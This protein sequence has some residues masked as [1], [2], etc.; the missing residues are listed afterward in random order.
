MIWALLYIAV[1]AF[2]VSLLAP[3]ALRPILERWG[4]LD[5]PNDRSSHTIATLR[6]GGL[7]PLAGWTIGIATTALLLPDA[8]AWLAILGVAV[9]V[10]ALLGLVDDLRSLPASPR[11]VVQMLVSAAAAFAIAGPH[12]WMAVALAAIII[13]GYVNT[14]NFMDGINALSGL[15]GAAV[16]LSFMSAGILTAADWLAYVGVALAASFAAFLPWNL[17]RS[18]LF[19]GDVGSYALGSAIAIT[20]VL[21]ISQGLPPLLVLAPLAI[22]VADTAA[23]ML[24]RL[25]RG[26][27]I[28]SPHR[29]HTYQRLTDV[30]LTHV[31]TAGVVTSFA[32]TNWLIATLVTILGV[33]TWVAV[34]AIILACLVYLSLPDWLGHHASSRTFNMPPSV[35]VRSIP[36]SPRHRVEKWAVLGA[37]GFVGS[38]VVAELRSRDFAVIEVRAPRLRSQMSSQHLSLESELSSLSSHT[39]VDSLAASLNGADVVVNAAGVAAPDGATDDSLYGANALLPAVVAEAAA[40]AGA[41]R[42]VHLSSAAVQGRRSCLDASSDVAPFSPYSHSKALG[43]RM[44]LT[45]V[46]QGTELQVV[47]LRATSVQGSG[48]KT[49]EQLRRIS[50]SP[51]ASVAGRGDAPSVVSSISRLAETAIDLGTTVDEVPGIVLQPWEGLSAGRILEAAGGGRAPKHLPSWLC[52]FVVATGFALSR[53]VPRFVGV[54]RRLEV[55]WFGQSQVAGWKQ[56]A[57]VDESRELLEILEGGLR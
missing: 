3:F 14:T 10:F 22:Y 19:L 4:V 38:A 36:P 25:L 17:R 31:A 46:E 43:E 39:D 48:R 11:F 29:T 56:P 16:G 1:A 51:F 53:V 18:G 13:V 49:T 20:A 37:T 30:G 28:A 24:R 42:L 27:N 5:V 54:T 57:K 7:A 6:A 2:G 8:R 23:T 55:M 35:A 52:R 45:I 21:A 33:S 26:E 50:Q 32:V 41:K 44:L 34:A 47:I 12:G 9:I 15:H 40:I